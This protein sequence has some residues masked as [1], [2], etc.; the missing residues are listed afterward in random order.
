MFLLLVC[1]STKQKQSDITLKS[2]VSSDYNFLLGKKI[3]HLNDI[4]NDT[5][6]SENNLILL[7]NGFDC[8]SC[9]SDGFVIAKNIDSIKG[10]HYVKII[11][12][13]SSKGT[14]QYYNKY[15]NY[16]YSDDRDLIRKELKYIQTPVFISIN[17]D[18]IINEL[19][20]HQFASKN[21]IDSFLVRYK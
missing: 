5:L 15:T 6:N 10:F 12:I 21:E 19:F 9:I 11:S 2:R 17:K 3:S 7:Y 14:D 4:L 18:G 13:T 1:C 20:F 16:I 8:G